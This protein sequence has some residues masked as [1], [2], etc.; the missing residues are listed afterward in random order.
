MFVLASLM[1]LAAAG[2][3]L[4]L[5]GSRDPEDD[6]TDTLGPTLGPPDAGEIGDVSSD[7]AEQGGDDGIDWPLPLPSPEPL[8][9]DDLI[10]GSDAGDDLQG[11]LG[12]DTIAAGAGNDWVQGDGT[13]DQPGWDEIHGGAG[14]DS[15]AGQGGDD[16]VW[17]DEGDD[18]I[19]GGEGNDSLFGGSGNDWISGHDGDDILV[20]GGGGD[21][22]D[23]GRGNDQLVGDD[24]PQTAWL[25]GGEGD[26]TLMPG[27]AD[28][29]E[30]QEGADDFVVKPGAAELPV[31]ADFDAREDQMILHLPDSVAQ[32]AKIDL[33]PD[34]DGTMLVTLNGDP[35]ARMLQG[36]GLTVADIVIVRLPG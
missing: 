18:T 26:D 20:A 28:F 24:D 22:L 23:G 33:T 29:A 32:D 8:A 9:G 15:L 19:L 36:G 30:G 27:S 34:Q 7:T 4:D 5:T 10:E 21:D 3:A 14:D 31:I 35:I 13:F 12:N 11:G 17:G 2:A 6:E 16:I 25:H 1:A